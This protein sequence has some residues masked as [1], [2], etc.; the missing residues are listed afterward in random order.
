MANILTRELIESVVQALPIQYRIM[1]RLLLMQYLD[2]TQEDIEHMAAD[3][4][5]PRLAQGEKP[6][7]QGLSRHAI[8]SVAERAEQYQGQVRQ[9]R[10][11]IFL[12]MESTQ[13]QIAYSETL[14]RIAEELLASQCGYDP[15]TIQDLRQSARAAV[16]RPALR[17]LDR[18]WEADEI[19]EDEYKK[20]RLP[21]EYQTELRRLER[22]RRR[23]ELAKRE[24]MMVGS[25]PL[26]DHEI[27][28]IWGIPLGSLAARKVKALHHY[29]QTVQSHI[30]G[31]GT[32]PPDSP[33]S[34]V[35]LWKETFATL[36]TSPVQRSVAVYEG[37]EGTEAALLDK[38]TAFANGTLPEDAESRF[39]QIVSRDYSPNAVEGQGKRQSLF[40][41]Q[42][43]SAI[44]SEL[45]LSPDSVEQELLT[46]ISPK[47]KVM[48]GQEEEIPAATPELGDMA[49]H[50]LRSFRGEDRR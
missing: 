49:E 33:A 35:D 12:Q 26:Q 45:D 11:R 23:Y 43:L 7:R 36:S 50:V 31:S 42:R 29:L 37:L 34:P 4:P 44:M 22:V 1:I 25:T 10:E 32:V 40:A 20:A 13:K 8:E 27:A 5:D 38:L 21:I 39:W 14:C 17:A 9:K 28:H 19:P 24:L 47:P 15:T 46:R 41:L 18:K 3:R 2:V 6:T 16:P 30:D 48:P